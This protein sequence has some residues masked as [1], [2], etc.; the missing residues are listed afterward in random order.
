MTTSEMMSMPVVKVGANQHGD[1]V[2]DGVYCR[3][4]RGNVCLV[5]GGD[6][7]VERKLA[8][9]WSL[10]SAADLVRAE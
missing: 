4:P 9:G 2:T 10:A 6:A 7:V 3:D 8:A 5:V 1:L